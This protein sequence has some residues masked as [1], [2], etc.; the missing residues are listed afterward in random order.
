MTDAKKL[1]IIAALAANLTGE[2]FRFQVNK[3]LANIPESK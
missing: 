1:Q 2:E 3:L